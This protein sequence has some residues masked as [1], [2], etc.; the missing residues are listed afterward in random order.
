MRLF[1]DESIGAY[2]LHSSTRDKG[3]ELQLQL[4]SRVCAPQR[5]EHFTYR[6]QGGRNVPDDN[7]YA[8]LS[9]FDA[10]DPATAGRLVELFLE[11]SSSF[12]TESA[13]GFPAP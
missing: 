11:Y 13:R 7:P 8:V 5:Y 2:C 9:L 4:S 6:H 1:F 3:D 10:A 12:A